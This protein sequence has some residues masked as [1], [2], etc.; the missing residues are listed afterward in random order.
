MEST[1]SM[2]SS[3]DIARTKKIQ[4]LTCS[5]SSNNTSGNIKAKSKSTASA[6]SVKKTPRPPN[7]FLIYRSEQASNYPGLIAPTLS[8]ILAERWRNE[9]PERL[10]Y[11]TE[12]AAQ[13]K[14]EHALKYPHYKFTP[15]KRGTG[16]R[17]RALQ[18]AAALAAKEATSSQPVQASGPKQ[19]KPVLPKNRSPCSSIRPIVDAGTLITPSPSP[20]PLDLQ[21]KS[22]FGN[23]PKR[24]IQRP[25]RFSPCGY[26]EKPQLSLRIKNTRI[27]EHEPCSA[28]GE[29]LSSSLF[30]H[31]HSDNISIKSLK[32]TR[33]SRSIKALS[34]SLK[35]LASARS[36]KSEVSSQS[37]KSLSDTCLDFFEQDEF[38]DEFLSSVDDE[39]GYDDSD[40]SDCE[41]KRMIVEIAAT[42]STTSTTSYLVGND[43]KV[44]DVAHSST[45]LSTVDSNQSTLQP[46]DPVFYE[47]TFASPYTMENF[48]PECLPREGHQ[49][50]SAALVGAFEVFPTVP[51]VDPIS[52]FSEYM[53][54]TPSFEELVV[55]FPEYASLEV[56]T[57]LKAEGTENDKSVVDSDRNNRVPLIV[58]TIAAAVLYSPLPDDAM[59][60]LSLLSPTTATARAMEN[61]SLSSMSSINVE[62]DS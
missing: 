16:K 45:R 58:N 37:S 33:S 50:P 25:E 39:L 36:L 26:R 32:S 56:D 14:K 18:A 55:D 49:W 21:E 57:K 41:D 17:A 13:A 59:I 44:K 22:T 35:S 61:M 51:Y 2:A 24:N 48:E 11:Y 7:S 40:D 8:A 20:P 47:T 15:V 12:L 31:S 9:T 42:T 27:P 43:V 19:L 30:F 62:D 60:P 46:Q 6:S 53:C 10:Q 1:P 54:T 3:V 34:R 4:P 23:R 5:T 52:L 38:S 29:A 28:S